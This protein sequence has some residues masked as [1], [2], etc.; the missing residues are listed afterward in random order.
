MVEIY[1]TVNVT[2]EDVQPSFT[3]IK[4]IILGNYSVVSTTKQEITLHLVGLVVFVQLIGHVYAH[5]ST[6]CLML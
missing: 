6:R 2:K 4:V 1:E 3:C 5:F